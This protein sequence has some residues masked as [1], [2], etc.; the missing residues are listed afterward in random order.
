MSTDVPPQPL[1]TALTDLVPMLERLRRLDADTVVR[2]RIAPDLLAA[3]APVPVGV[4]VG[5]TVRM[6]G[7]AETPADV[8]VGAGALSDMLAARDVDDPSPLPLPPRRDVDWHHT[9]PPRTGWTRVAELTDDQV[10]GAVRAA[11][12]AVKAAPMAAAAEL[13]LDATAF[14]N[15]TEPTVAG[16]DRRGPSALVKLGFLPRGGTTAVDT[17]GTWTRLV[18]A[19]GSVYL[20]GGR[21]DSSA[22]P[23]LLSL[24]G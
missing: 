3:V 1:A 2:L 10:R 12:T 20:H 17:S 4:L 21:G 11:A 8:T 5:R 15:A 9:M 22:G 23:S 18:A 16:L 7:G 24:L 6:P 13:A 14:P 19:Y